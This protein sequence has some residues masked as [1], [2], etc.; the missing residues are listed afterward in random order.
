MRL[1]RARYQFFHSM[2]KKYIICYVRRLGT[3]SRSGTERTFD[4][5]TIEKMTE[6]VKVMK[7]KGAILTTQKQK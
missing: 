1:P 4:T 3:Q 6:I 2:F 7:I 5:Q